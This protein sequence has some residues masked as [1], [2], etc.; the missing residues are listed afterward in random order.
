M[1]GFEHDIKILSY[2]RVSFPFTVGNLG[3]QIKVFIIFFFPGQRLCNSIQAKN[4][5]I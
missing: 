3:G 4:V 1:I 2:F 5:R